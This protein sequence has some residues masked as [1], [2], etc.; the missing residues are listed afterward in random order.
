MYSLFILNKKKRLKKVLL[1]TTNPRLITRVTNDNPE[2]KDLSGWC[3][4][5]IEVLQQWEGGWND[6]NCN[7]FSGEDFHPGAATT[8]VCMFV[9][10]IASRK[11]RGQR[12]K[13]SLCKLA[14]I[15]LEQDCTFYSTWKRY[16]QNYCG[17]FFPPFILHDLNEISNELLFVFWVVLF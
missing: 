17:K 5:F 10:W 4:R 11:C 6:W 7:L 1:E 15:K 12:T 13:G 16:M 2:N 14:D 3:L 8:N 9:W